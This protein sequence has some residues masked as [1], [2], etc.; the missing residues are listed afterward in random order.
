M[1]VL[2]V[3]AALRIW[4][5][6]WPRITPVLWG[7]ISLLALNGL[8]LLLPSEAG[9]TARVAIFRENV[10]L[11][12]FFL[13][14]TTM[15]LKEGEVAYLVR[16]LVSIAMAMVLFGYV[17]H[18]LLGF[19]FWKALGIYELSE[20]KGVTDTYFFLPGGIP[21]NFV[22][23][24]FG[25]PIHRMVGPLADPTLFSHYL[26]LPMLL[27]LAGRE[28]LGLDRRVW[29]GLV[30]VLG[31]AIALSLGRGGLL[32]VLCGLGLLLWLEARRW[33]LVLL[34]LALGGGGVLLLF[35]LKSGIFS[36]APDSSGARHLGGLLL[37]LQGLAE[38]PLGHGLGTAGNLAKVFARGSLKGGAGESFVGSLAW[39]LGLPGVLGWALFCLSVAW[40][41]VS[42]PGRGPRSEGASARLYRVVGVSLVGIFLTSVVSE[43]AVAATGSGLAYL[44]AGALVASRPA[45]R[46]REPVE[47]PI[48][49]GAA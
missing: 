17:E 22:F 1:I 41:L 10:V 33:R 23:Y 20:A 42:T 44:L 15:N 14:G 24:D 35:G 4:E 29:V 39:Q 38:H 9:W 12:L 40:S 25:V 36:L 13:A 18:F 31:S 7:A 8:Y 2:G 43:S 49:G 47:D 26:A 28:V 21:G 37:N 5:R 19:P 11:I 27:L 34:L 16:G 30:L 3:V 46:P 32:V 6:R 45:P 48:L